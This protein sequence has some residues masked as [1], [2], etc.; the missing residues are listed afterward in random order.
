M[1]KQ[2]VMEQTGN[3][4]DIEGVIPEKENQVPADDANTKEDIT[5]FGKWDRK[6]VEKRR[7]KA[8]KKANKKQLSTSAK[9][10]I[11][12]G[13]L[14]VGGSVLYA[15][16]KAIVNHYS[17]DGAAYEPEGGSSENACPE[18]SALD[19]YE[20]ISSGGPTAEE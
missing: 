20:A 10:G 15:V 11:G 9:I 7:M 19:A 16:G 18:P 3:V 13:G 2:N 6:I 1:K 5:I 12:A 17:G 8:E 14:A 4:V